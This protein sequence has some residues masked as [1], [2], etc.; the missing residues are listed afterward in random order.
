MF[1]HRSILYLLCNIRLVQLVS[2]G[3]FLGFPLWSVAILAQAILSF[4]LEK[5][6]VAK[7]A[8]H[9]LSYRQHDE[10]FRV[11]GIPKCFFG[12]VVCRRLGVPKSKNHTF[13][14]KLRFF[15]LAAFG[16][17]AHK[18]FFS[19]KCVLGLGTPGLQTNTW[20]NKHCGIPLSLGAQLVMDR[21][22]S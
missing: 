21:A 8:Q 13:S 1:S 6:C 20:P 4:L 9:S 16:G 10:C 12:Q 17:T 5:P 11:R 15:G 7:A 22:C 2:R 14:G 18:P 19:C 3:P